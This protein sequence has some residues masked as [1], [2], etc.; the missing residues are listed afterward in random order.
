M[1]GCM[2][3]GASKGR[4]YGRLPLSL[5]GLVAKSAGPPPSAPQYAGILDTPTT[6]ALSSRI[7]WE[8]VYQDPEDPF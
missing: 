1:G 7:P 2:P 5:L 4:W 8:N 6:L 3:L